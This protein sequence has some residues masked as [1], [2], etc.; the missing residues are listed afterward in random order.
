MSA[1]QN[2][3]IFNSDNDTDNPLVVECDPFLN[4]ET[5]SYGVARCY[6]FYAKQSLIPTIFELLLG[7]GTVTANVFTF[8][9]ILTRNRK[10]FVF[11]KILMAHTIVD[12]VVGGIDLP[13]YH[14]FTVFG[15]WPFSETACIMW[16]SLDSSLN[17]ITILHMLYMSYARIQSIINPKQYHY[18][19]LIKRTPLVCI[20]IWFIGF[21]IWVR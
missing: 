3:S 13:I 17:T 14:I 16:S 20:S 1:T 19:F 12:F 9:L 8:F 21:L 15:Y 4:N 10:K 2:F 18:G 5:D 7:I 6:G 11:D